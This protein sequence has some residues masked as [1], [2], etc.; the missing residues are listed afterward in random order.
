MPHT[1]V[2]IGVAPDAVDELAHRCRAALA[3]LPDGTVLA[4]LTAARLHGL[5]LPSA[6]AEEP[7]EV[8]L[9]GVG[10]VPRA[11]SGS[12][13][14]DVRGRRRQLRRAEVVVQDGLPLTCAPR[15]WVDLAERLPM[16]DLVAAGDSLLRR[17]ASAR[18]VE[19]F[20]ADARGRRGIVRARSAVTLLDPRSGSRPESHLRFGLLAAGLPA[21]AVNTAIYD[22]HGQWLAEPDLH[23]KQARLCLEYNGAMH[24]DVGRMRRDITRALDVARAEWL[25]LTFGPVQVFQRMSESVQIVRTYL[26][27]RDAGWRRRLRSSA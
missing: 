25:T 26:D 13:R 6:R 15:T 7:I 1:A 12:M 21:P 14:P 20:I 16:P 3:R 8:I 23:Y 22:E 5:W 11:V 4:G 2:M 19:L 10:I 18:E 24:A 17:H 27:I 9:R